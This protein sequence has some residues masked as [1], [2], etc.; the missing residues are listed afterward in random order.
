MCGGGIKIN[1]AFG[2][3]ITVSPRKRQKIVW[4]VVLT[5]NRT[6]KSQHSTLNQVSE[7]NKVKTV[8]VCF[9]KFFLSEQT[10]KPVQSRTISL[11]GCMIKGMKINLDEWTE[12]CSSQA[13]WNASNWMSHDVT[14]PRPSKSSAHSTR[15]SNEGKSH[16]HRS[17]PWHRRWIIGFFLD[18]SSPG[19]TKFWYVGCSWAHRTIP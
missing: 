11:S 3:E 10:K 6:S 13:L 2:I 14:N 17:P 15:S 5:K 9:L 18:L 19:G 7:A 1:S 4:K 12:K 16:G 8:K